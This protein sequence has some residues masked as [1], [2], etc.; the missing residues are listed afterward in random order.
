[1]IHPDAE[2]VFIISDYFNQL[3]N[4]LGNYIDVNKGNLSDDQRNLLYDSQIDL[5]R[6]A[7]TINMLGVELVF[8]DLQDTL[9]K[10][11]EITDRIDKAVKKALAVQHAIDIAT[12]LVSI[13]NA[14]IAKDPKSIVTNTIRAGKS[15]SFKKLV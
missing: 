13:G 10:I 15:L 2:Q 4:L 14:I 9:E 11:G 7:G 8:E 12:A 6:F 5:S 3:A 1:M